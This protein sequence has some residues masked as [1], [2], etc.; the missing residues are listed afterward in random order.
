MQCDSNF[1][2]LRITWRVQ[3]RT[4]DLA[5]LISCLILLLIQALGEPQFGRSD[6]SNL[7]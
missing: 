6:R 7:I 5:F 3:D 4:E 1:S 2:M